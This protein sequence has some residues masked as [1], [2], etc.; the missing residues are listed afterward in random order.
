MNLL[1]LKKNKGFSAL[2]QFDVSSLDWLARIQTKTNPFQF[3]FERQY[4]WNEGLDRPTLPM[5][6]YIPADLG[7]H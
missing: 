3:L 4:P 5:L 2:I 7:V 1:V 6:N